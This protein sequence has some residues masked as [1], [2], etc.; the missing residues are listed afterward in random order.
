MPG[1]VA[2]SRDVSLAGLPAEL[3]KLAIAGEIDWG[4]S[5]RDVN[6]F[7]TGKAKE[8]FVQQRGPLGKWPPLKRARNRAKDRRA[9]KKGGVQKILIDSAL[10]MNS[11]SSVSSVRGG[12]REFRKFSVET[13]SVVNYAGFHDQGTRNMPARPAVGVTE[14]FANGVADVVADRLVRQYFGV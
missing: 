6:V 1:G 13:G 8:A 7:A 5:L 10:L 12:V 11:Y 3:Q 2:I 4:P 14:E 9:A